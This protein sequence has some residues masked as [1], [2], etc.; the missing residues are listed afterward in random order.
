MDCVN[1]ITQHFDDVDTAIVPSGTSL[2]RER[3][4]PLYTISYT[5]PW[6][7]TYRYSAVHDVASV[8]DSH[9]DYRS[10]CFFSSHVVLVHSKRYEAMLSIL[11]RVRDLVSSLVKALRSQTEPNVV[12]II[13]YLNTPYQETISQNFL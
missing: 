4:K 1:L 11:N 6:S 12:V 8:L 5:A 7:M 3:M 9:W 13:T 10:C 2:N